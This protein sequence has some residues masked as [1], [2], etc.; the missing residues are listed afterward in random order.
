MLPWPSGARLARPRS[1]SWRPAP[2][3][4]LYPARPIGG[5]ERSLAGR[6]D[7]PYQLCLPEEEDLPGV[8]VDG[9]N[10]NVIEQ[11][12]VAVIQEVLQDVV[13]V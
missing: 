13:I 1:W 4:F 8:H 12:D 7:V 3:P 5:S 11:G 10:L 9:N 2:G 6:W